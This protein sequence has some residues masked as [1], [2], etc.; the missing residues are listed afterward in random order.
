M[1]QVVRERL[2][3]DREALEKELLN[4]QSSPTADQDSLSPEAQLA[5]AQKQIAALTQALESSAQQL[6]AAN[7]ERDSFQQRCLTLTEQLRLAIRQRFA[8]SSERSTPLTV[9]EQD[10]LFD[11]VEA[12]ALA[13]A[14]AGAQTP[15]PTPEN[16]GRRVSKKRGA[17]LVNMAELPEIE[18][19]LELPEDQR[20]CAHCH[21]S[22]HEMG[23][24][25]I[26]KELEHIPARTVVRH[27]KLVKYA[28]RHCAKHDVARPPVAAPVPARPFRGT[29]ASPSLVA[30]ILSQKFELA[31][32]LY[33]LENY[34]V[35]RGL[36]LSRQTMANW[37]I[38]AAEMLAKLCARM[39]AYLLKQPVLAADETTV[40]VLHEAGRKATTPS[41]M[42]VYCNGSQ[43]PPLILFDYQMTRAAR[44]PIT[45]LNGFTGYLQVDGYS[46]YDLVP[47]VTLAGCWAH[48]RRYYEEAIQTLLPEDRKQ[49]RSP[50]FVGRDYCNQLFAVEVQ[51]KDVTPEERHEQ[52]QVLSTP[53]LEA[54]HAWLVKQ[55]PTIL[56][57]SKLGKAV[58]YSLNQWGKLKN[59]LL[60]GRI[61]LD[62]NRVERAI[63]PFA[64][65]RKNWYFCNTPAGADASAMAYS[66]VESAKANGLVPERYLKHL[67]EKLPALHAEDH[68]ALDA[69]L[70]WQPGVQDTC[71]KA[72]VKAALANAT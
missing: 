34:F 2:R 41:R 27:I 28:C 43:G 32:A 30:Y 26:A 24:E 70:P 29:M 59:F 37:V 8:P 57:K 38:R 63:R 48:A 42:W 33:R 65:G 61:E 36:E 19:R 1:S 54:Y 35:G 51:L 64:L 68:D 7:R 12:L 56:P 23:V 67:F 22:L 50:A 5:H 13:G 62:N 18:E 53:I 58:G 20:H 71:S 44:H 72:A 52:R 16:I 3:R 11:E 60:D 21:H 46:A 39:H 66:I 17:S 4:S 45:F 25:T 10:G 9:P 55:G 6:E 40:Q 31:V 49:G 15:E 69:L 47:Q 14:M